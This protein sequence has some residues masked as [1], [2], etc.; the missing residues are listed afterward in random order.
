MVTEV[1]T[2]S[3]L[4]AYR[5]VVEQ[6]VIHLRPQSSDLP[7]GAEVLVVAVQ[8]LPSIKDQERRLDAL[9]PEEWRKPFEAFETAV[10]LEQ[11]EVDIDTI[12]D[13]ELVALVHQAREETA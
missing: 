1:M 8:S 9:S 3:V 12:S 10:A 2:M 13:D 4:T 5:G 6:G 7:D 11:P